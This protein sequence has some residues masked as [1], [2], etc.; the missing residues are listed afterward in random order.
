MDRLID[1]SVWV[2]YFSPRGQRNH[3]VLDALE[4]W[5]RDD[6]VVTVLPVLAEIQSGKV[7]TS[8]ARLL[9]YLRRVDPDWNQPEV[10]KQIAGFAHPHP[11]VGLVDRM[12]LFSS[13]EAR[14]QLVTFDQRLARAAHSLGVGKP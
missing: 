7:R 9:P 3:P 1:T 13:L 4:G 10:W 12:I 14:C 8:L 11:G 5:I 6:E 2:D